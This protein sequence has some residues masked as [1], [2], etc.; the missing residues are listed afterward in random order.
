MQKSASGSTE[1]ILVLRMRL[2][3]DV[4]IAS[5]KNGQAYQI[6]VPSIKK[7]VKRHLLSPGC[8]DLCG[9][10]LHRP[11]LCCVANVFGV[12]CRLPRV[13]DGKLA[14]MIPV[15]IYFLSIQENRKARI[16]K[17]FLLKKLLSVAEVLA[18]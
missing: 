13:R 11:H 18:N 3:P 17:D 16:V 14:E 15:R 4:I 12:G 8:V 10:E 1:R 2:G 9:Y 5:D 6:T 7:G